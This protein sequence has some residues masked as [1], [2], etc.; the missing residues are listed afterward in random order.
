MQE[1]FR[2]RVDAEQFDASRKRLRHSLATAS[3]RLSIG[4]TRNRQSNHDHFRFPYL[5]SG[6]GA[7]SDELDGEMWPVITCARDREVFTNSAF[8]RFSGEHP[9]LSGRGGASPEMTTHHDPREEMR[10]HARCNAP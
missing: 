7:P 2:S 1:G 10:M 6:N 9:R 4:T 5:R 8:R 3:I